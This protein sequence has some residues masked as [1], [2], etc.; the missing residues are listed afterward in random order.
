M[1]TTSKYNME[2]FEKMYM[3]HIPVKDIAKAIGC[4]EGYAR[5]IIF[6]RKLKMKRD[7]LEE[8]NSKSKVSAEKPKISEVRIT[9]IDEKT[10]EEKEKE[11]KLAKEKLNAKYDFEENFRDPNSTLSKKVKVYK[12]YNRFGMPT[13]KNLELNGYFIIDP[14]ERLV[15]KD[16]ICY[17]AMSLDEVKYA[18][19]KNLKV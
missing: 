13:L 9:N 17:K 1:K 10:K 6:N 5:V 19:K 2:L 12:S 14:F 3:D 11:L 7:L 18:L 16:G 4:T 8:K 15:E